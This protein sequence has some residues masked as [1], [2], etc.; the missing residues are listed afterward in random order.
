MDYHMDR[1]PLSEENVVSPVMRWLPRLV[2]VGTMVGFVALAWYA[3]RTGTQSVRDEDLL[4]VEADKTPV[5]EKPTD[6][7]GMKFP[8]QDK[9]IFETFA[10]NAQTPPKVE[11][12]MPAPEEPMPK[13][14]DT[15]DTKTW[16]NDKLYKKEEEKAAEDA[17]PAA[18]VPGKTEEIIAA[19]P[20][21]KIITIPPVKEPPL[22][23]PVATVKDIPKPSPVEPV[24]DVAANNE[25][26]SYTNKTP[27]H[28]EK[29]APVPAETESKPAPAAKIEEE[30]I[31]KPAEK[32]V[33]KPSAASGVKIQLGA[34]GSEKEAKEAFAKMQKKFSSLGGKSPIVVRADLGAKGIFYRLRV[35][36]FADSASAKAFCG[37]VSAKGQACILAQ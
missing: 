23:A 21:A 27:A 28:A 22:L 33:V 34:Y 32:A 30:K 20:K 9:T 37:S 31:E 7:G 12:L 17:K 19:S 16:V 14:L 15:S 2:V 4:V 36:G 13:R 6:P 26:V 3:Y 1:D 10:N 35:G 24:R 18:P 8:N 29:T 5:K 11:R 25:V